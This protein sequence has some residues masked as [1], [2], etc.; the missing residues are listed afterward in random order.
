MRRIAATLVLLALGISV[1]RTTAAPA[2]SATGGV[3]AQM[4][5]NQ[6]FYYIGDP[7]SVRISISNSGS[8]E[9]SNPVKSS[10]FA[11]F[12]VSDSQGKRLEAQAKPASQEPSRPAKLAPNAFYG[13]V[14]D[15][16]QM[17]PQVRAKGRYTIR[18]SA[19]GVAS[20]EFVVTVIPKFDPSKEYSARVETEQ[21]AFVIDLMKR[22]APIAVKAFV[23]LA[24][25]GFYDGLL[26]HE[27]RGDQ[28]VGGGDPT[29]S[30]GGQAPFR[31][32]AELAQIP[33][34]AGSVL[35]KPAGLAPPANSSQFVIT[36]QPQPGWVGQFTVLG[37]V[38]DGLDIVK[39]LSNVAT[40]D[41][42][43][44]K[45]L[46][47]V[48]TQHVTIVERGPSAGAAAEAKP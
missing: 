48:H 38:V 13:A 11:S 31:Y 6:Q 45:P 26:I 33:I 41:R 2:A 25:A 28:I 43:S 39:K 21:G 18:W 37:Q 3:R 20:D 23:D 1:P 5:L 12:S 44:F 22:T 9:V 42:P 19:D 46:K 29:G 47:D 4:E 40:A 30:G 35:L 17:Y 34:V 36:L 15:L 16:S 27:A 8:T 24:N 32:P 14:V 10:L 7:L